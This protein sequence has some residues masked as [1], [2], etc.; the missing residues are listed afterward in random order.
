MIYLRLFVEFFKTGLFAIGGGLATIPF[1]EDLAERTGWF[2]KLDL[3]NMIA[4]SESTP[5]AIGVNMATYVGYQTQGILGCIV[6][7]LGLVTPSVI[8]ILIE[9]QFL[10]RFSEHRIVKAAMFGLRAASAALI[11]AAGLSV[12]QE[13]LVHMDQ[14]S[15]G[16]AAFFDWRALLR[17]ALLA[18]GTNCKKLK[19]LHPIVFIA[20]AGVVGVVFGFAGV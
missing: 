11:T 10:R 8:V 3:L 16:L 18:V 13:T 17:F 7:T 12:A 4:V 2:T 1:L 5:G 9:A 14:W 19:K 15:A 6:A 20:V